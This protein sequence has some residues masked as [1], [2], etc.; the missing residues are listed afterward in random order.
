MNLSDLPIRKL[1]EHAGIVLLRAALV[2]AVGFALVN[3]L[4]G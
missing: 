2:L 3:S 4:Q 1:G